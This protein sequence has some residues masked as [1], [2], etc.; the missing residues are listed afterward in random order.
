MPDPLTPEDVAARPV[1]VRLSRAKG[2]RMPP[3]TVRVC[4]PGALGNPYIISKD[5][6]WQVSIC[7]NGIITRW[8]CSSR[9]DAQSV[10]ADLFRRRLADQ[11]AADPQA[12]ALMRQR[13]QRKNL[14]CWCRLDQPCH[15]D[16]LLEIANAAD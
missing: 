5:P 3:N 2:W 10:A 1:R 7:E 8:D 9:E 14:A 16:V 4:R 6:T 15:A 11:C 13:L 12:A